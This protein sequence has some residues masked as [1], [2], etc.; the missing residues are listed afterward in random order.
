MGIDLLLY[1][2]YCIVIGVCLKVALDNRK[3]PRL[4]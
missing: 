2:V 4:P 1:T 3:P